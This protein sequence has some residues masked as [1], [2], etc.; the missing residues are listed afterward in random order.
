MHSM[1][2]ATFNIGGMHCASC[3]ARNERTLRKIQGVL[4]AT[5]NFATH[6]AR[7]VFDEALVS[8]G[9]LHDVVIE[10][11]YQ[12]LTAEFAEDHQKSAQRERHSARRRA[13]LALIFAIPVAALAMFEVNLPWTLFGR[14]LSLWVESAFPTII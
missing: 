4:D 5:V 8:E 10:N 7:V 12:V 3:S 2:T 9:K 1:K 14:N 11:G 6:S 13:F